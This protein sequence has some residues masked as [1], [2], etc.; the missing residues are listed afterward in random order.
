[1]NKTWITNT[2]Y[3][4]KPIM[5][6]IYPQYLNECCFSQGKKLSLLLLQIHVFAQKM[7]LGNNFSLKH[8]QIWPSITVTSFR[9]SMRYSGTDSRTY[10]PLPFDNERT[11]GNLKVELI[12][13]Q[14]DKN[15]NNTLFPWTVL[16]FLGDY[17]SQ[18]MAIQ[19]TLEDKC[20][21]YLH[22]TT[23]VNNLFL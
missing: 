12:N 10:W 13:L 21:W 5:L 15:K 7:Y 6:I 22:P 1:M 8:A 3:L 4:S 2:S 16:N 19:R 11:P 14:N 9:G 18:D 20:S 23:F 17:T